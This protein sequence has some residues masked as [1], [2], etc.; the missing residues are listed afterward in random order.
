MISICSRVLVSGCSRFPTFYVAPVDVGKYTRS[1]RNDVGPRVAFATKILL[2][3]RWRLD[4]VIIRQWWFIGN[5]NG[6]TEIRKMTSSP[7]PKFRRCF[8]V[9]KVY[10]S[11][12]ARNFWRSTYRARKRDDGQNERRKIHVV[13]VSETTDVPY[14]KSA[15]VFE[16]V[17]RFCKTEERVRTL[18]RNNVRTTL[19][20]CVLVVTICL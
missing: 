19:M 16:N 5:A 4:G 18:I 9:F 17:E 20:S 13:V 15:R 2:A 1:H 12:T 10:E 14:V 3:K 7:P 6:T 11:G 8:D